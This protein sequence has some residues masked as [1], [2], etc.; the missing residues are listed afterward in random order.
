MKSLQQ[1]MVLDSS[2]PAALPTCQDYLYELPHLIKPLD[3]KWELKEAVLT[4]Q[5]SGLGTEARMLYRQ[6]APLASWITVFC[7]FELTFSGELIK[8]MQ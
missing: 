1:S 5:C 7:V 4:A 2:P 3:L 8:S 6:A